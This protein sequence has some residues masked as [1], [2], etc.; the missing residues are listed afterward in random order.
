[1]PVSYTHLEADGAQ[2][3]EDLLIARCRVGDQDVRAQSIREKVGSLFDDSDLRANPLQ[4][5]LG[6][7]DAI[8]EDGSRAGT[9][10][11]LDQA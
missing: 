4:R 1:M 7:I 11:C 5:Y 2:C 10:V 9:V 6:D 8:D 3:R